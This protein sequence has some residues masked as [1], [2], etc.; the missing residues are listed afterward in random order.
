MLGLAL[1]LVLA[2]AV[3]FVVELGGPGSPLPDPTCLGGAGAAW[4]GNDKAGRDRELLDEP[5]LLQ[6]SEP[7]TGSNEQKK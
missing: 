7:A 4:M 2:R 6:E 5:T 3:T 1:G